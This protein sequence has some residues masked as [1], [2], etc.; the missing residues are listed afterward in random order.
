MSVSLC[1]PVRCFIVNWTQG[2]QTATSPRPDVPLI[3]VRSGDL[4]IFVRE[5]RRSLPQTS[6]VRHHAGL[7]V[8]SPT[9]L[10]GSD[11]LDDE[12]AQLSQLH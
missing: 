3:V 9:E 4:S 2:G 6:L 5:G 11:T 8:H 1:R 12:K 7:S 10:W